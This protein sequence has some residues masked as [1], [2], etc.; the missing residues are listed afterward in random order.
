MS[1]YVYLFCA[2]FRDLNIS[3]I[4]PDATLFHKAGTLSE[5]FSSKLV[6]VFFSATDFYDRNAHR[7]IN[8]VVTTYI[9]AV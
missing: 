1:E 4:L 7:S 2:Y 6:V 5:K 9:K 8:Y 3:N